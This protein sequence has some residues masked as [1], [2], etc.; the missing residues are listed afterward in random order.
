MLIL[1]KSLPENPH[2]TQRLGYLLEAAVAAAVAAEGQ[3]RL[4]VIGH[5]KRSR[6]PPDR[7]HVQL[8]AIDGNQQVVIAV[9]TVR[10]V[11][12]QGCDLLA[13]SAVLVADEQRV[14]VVADF[15]PEGRFADGE[16]R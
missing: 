6:T 13:T 12:A 14:L 4:V 16:T 9:P 3:L 8:A 2:L 7:Q 10:S 5:L 11:F 1:T 15:A